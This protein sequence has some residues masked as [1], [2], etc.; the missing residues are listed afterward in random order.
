MAV[1]GELL[2]AAGGE[3]LMTVDKAYGVVHRY[4]RTVPVSLGMATRLAAA[5][6]P[7]SIERRV[8]AKGK[9]R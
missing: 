6:V 5:G 2:M 4:P 3:F 7:V 8:H 1:P 9:E